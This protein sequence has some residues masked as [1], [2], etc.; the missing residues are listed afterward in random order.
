MLVS[1]LSV[2][3]DLNRRVTVQ[4]GQSHFLNWLSELGD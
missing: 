1:H 2:E 3:G 4:L